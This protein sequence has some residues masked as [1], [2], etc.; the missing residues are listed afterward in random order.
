MLFL[1]YLAKIKYRASSN[2]EQLFIYY[3]FIMTHAILVNTIILPLLQMWD[4]V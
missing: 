3:T 2:A 1:N 4:F